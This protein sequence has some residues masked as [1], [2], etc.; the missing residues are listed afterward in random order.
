MSDL[1]DIALDDLVPSFADEQPDWPEVVLRSERKRRSW[2]TRHPLPLSRRTRLVLAVV[3]AGLVLVPA[4]V[5]VGTKIADY[6][7][8]TPAPPSVVRQFSFSKQSPDDPTQQAIAASLPHA[9]AS[10]AHGVIQEQTAYGP[11]DLW[12]A[13]NDWGGL[14]WFVDFA[15]DPLLPNGM[16]N[17]S[18]TCDTS[19]SPASNISFSGFDWNVSHPNLVTVTGRVYV[20]AATVQLTLADGSTATLPVVEGLYLGSLDKNAKVTQVT[21][22]DSAGNQVARWTPQS[23]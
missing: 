5:A 20:G 2:R 3:L 15:N 10:K 21:A 4:A 8:G 19:A 18:G 1:L 6:F 23:S 14:C 12:A 7:E 9:D 16:T 17:G 13:P 22:Y 11:V